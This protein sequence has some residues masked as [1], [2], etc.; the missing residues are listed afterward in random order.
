MDTRHQ[1][2]KFAS[3]PDFPKFVKVGAEVEYGVRKVGTGLGHDP[4]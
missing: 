4:P 2:P 3:A 1:H